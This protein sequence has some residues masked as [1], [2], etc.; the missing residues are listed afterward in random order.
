M[1][2]KLA[3]AGVFSLTFIITIMSIVRFV[4]NAPSSG[5]TVPSWLQAWSVIEQSLSVI[6][7][8]FASF[9]IYVINRTKTSKPSSSKGRYVN[10]FN[11]RKVRSA[12]T[13]S[14]FSHLESSGAQ[15][16]ANDK[17]RDSMDVELLDMVHSTRTD[18]NAIQLETGEPHFVASPSEAQKRTDA[19]QQG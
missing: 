9:R 14:G 1:R 13:K 2:Q 15:A 4:L 6:I 11:A 5:V 3:L 8:C 10:S 18:E 19:V 7:S 12:S 17:L 16:S